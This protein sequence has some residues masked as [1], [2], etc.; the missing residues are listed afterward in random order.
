MNAEEFAYW[1]QGALE[2]NPEMLKNGMTPEQAQTIQDHLDLVFD[3]VT[4]DRFNKNV[5]INVPTLRDFRIA[6]SGPSTGPPGSQLFCSQVQECSNMS[7]LK[8]IKKGPNRRKPVGRNPG[9][10]C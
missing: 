3:K 1:L 4:P 5:E 7:P 2:M 6:N 8:P 9:S 10:K